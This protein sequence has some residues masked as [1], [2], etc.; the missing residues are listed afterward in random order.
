MTSFK[1]VVTAALIASTALVPAAQACS[2]LAMDSDHGVVYVRS[3]DWGK[4]TGLDLV[5]FAAG[6]DLTSYEAEGFANQADAPAK[7]F[8]VA[9]VENDAF[10]G[11]QA[12]AHNDKG[13][14]VDTLYMNPSVDFIA[15][16]EDTGAPAVNLADAPGFI[17]SQYDNAQAVAEGYENGEFQIAW[18]ADTGDAGKHGLHVS[19]VDSNG[20]VTWFQLNEGGEVVMYTGNISDTD[21]GVK[22]NAPLLQDH[23]AAIEEMDA[24]AVDAGDRLPSDISS[25]SRHLRLTWLANNVTL[26]GMSEMEALGTVQNMYDSGASVPQQIIDSTINDTYTTWNTTRTILGSDVIT[27]R[28]YATAQEVSFSISDAKLAHEQNGGQVCA[29]ANAQARAGETVVTF[30]SCSA[31]S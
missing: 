18:S 24:T 2:R 20:D 9:W 5:T 21:L 7:N 6:D 22:A 31:G 1:K 25:S 4:K 3:V 29:D 16:Y 11:V 15:D 8:T 17:A 13:M 26:D 19:A 10:H 28:D 23:R 12:Q 27:V 30:G 14:V